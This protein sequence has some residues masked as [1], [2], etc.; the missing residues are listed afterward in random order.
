MGK[1]AEKG[2][3]RGVRDTGNSVAGTLA[4]GKSRDKPWEQVNS[5]PL[6]EASEETLC[7]VGGSLAVI[8]KPGGLSS[9]LGAQ[10]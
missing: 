1:G 8:E 5:V 4:K 6:K 10:L 3:E 7:L 2:A 9:C